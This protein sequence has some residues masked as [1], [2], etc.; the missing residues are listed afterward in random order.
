MAVH[1]HEGLENKCY[2]Y[3]N[4]W[5]YYRNMFHHGYL[6]YL[7]IENLHRVLDTGSY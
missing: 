2:L 1:E 5:A 4:F 7:F 3:F 6:F